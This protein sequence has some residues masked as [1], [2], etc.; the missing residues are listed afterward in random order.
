MVHIYHDNWYNKE[1][2][3]GHIRSYLWWWGELNSLSHIKH[4]WVIYIIYGTIIGLCNHPRK[5]M[6]AMGKSWTRRLVSFCRSMVRSEHSGMLSI[7]PFLI[8]IE[9]CWN[10]S[11]YKALLASTG[12]KENRRP[13]GR[14]R[15]HGLYWAKSLVRVSESALFPLLLNRNPR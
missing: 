14:G 6:I 11:T 2:I 7:N 12:S 4:I 8:G 3:V 5:E 15:T 10:E 9:G 13:P 1:M